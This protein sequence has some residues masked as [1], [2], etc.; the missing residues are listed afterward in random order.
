[1]IILCLHVNVCD[2]III[3]QKTN[4]LFDRLDIRS[5]R[6]LKFLLESKSVSKTAEHIELSQPATSRIVARL[7]KT[8][9]DP[10][11]VRTNNGYGLTTRA[12]QL[13]PKLIVALES[14]NTLFEV[15]DFDI[16]NIETSIRIASTDY[17]LVSVIRDLYPQLL[18]CAPG[19]DIELN[20]FTPETF[21]LIERG[22]LDLAL[23]ANFEIPGDFHY[24]I[25]F[26][27]NYSILVNDKHPLLKQLGKR[28][29]ITNEELIGWPT[30]EIL[31]PSITKMHNDDVINIDSLSKQADVRFRLPYFL[32]A[33]T[34]IE[35]TNTIAALPTRMCHHA[36]KHYAVKAIALENSESFTYVAIWH[37]RQH[38]RP[39]LR[40]LIEK[41]T[42]LGST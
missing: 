26:E 28:T 3:M 31:Y 39:L 11:L 8:L 15:D 36:Q 13:Y 16:S 29:S 22:E 14:M 21:S 33:A 24:R 4:T 38:Q 27:E 35:S 25:L 1:M 18:S 6:I 12:Q 40:W 41:I 37:H 20:N 7:R 30:A 17:G 34:L 9:G 10:L 32:A 19:L 42:E 5:L 23:F 2:S